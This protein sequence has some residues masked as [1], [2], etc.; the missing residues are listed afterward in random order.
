MSRRRITTSL[1]ATLLMGLGSAC[2]MDLPIAERI[3]N[4]RPLA[5]RV[6][7]VDPT[8][9]PDEAIRTEAMPTETITVRPFMV[10]DLGPISDERIE[11]EIEP[12]WLACPLQ[13]LQ[14][15][16]ACLSAQLPLTLDEVEDC[17]PV[18]FSALESGEL[19][20]IPA[21]CRL[22]GGTPAQPTMQVPLDFNFF[23]GGDLE[24]TMIGHRPDAGTTEGCANE[25]L[26]GDGTS[27][28]CIIAVQRASIG[29]DAALTRLAADF[30]LPAEQ[31]GPIPSEDE[32]PDADRHPRIQS[33]RVAIT[34][35][36]DLR[37]PDIARVLSESET[38]DVQRGDTITIVAGQTLVI[39]T[40]AP[41]EDLQT[42]LVPSDDSFEER[43][44]QYAG[45]WYRTWGTLLSPASDNR[46]SLNSWAMVPGE[47][48]DS[49]STVP[50]DDGRATLYYVLRDERQGVDWWWFHVQVL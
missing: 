29:P 25:L 7:V 36:E 35:E 21:P 44:E 50:P 28:D 27:G 40:I 31:L 33:F 22:T 32:V 15:I 23:V 2:A 17:P 42:F 5:M 26:S 16:F 41:E 45:A 38:V 30:G 24:L 12:I 48:D 37:G 20:A 19:P 1:I 14:G 47:Q 46:R 18:D 11:A 10:D 3:I 43:D 13:P 39:E 6:E 49:T 9:S 4:E 8:A 34:D